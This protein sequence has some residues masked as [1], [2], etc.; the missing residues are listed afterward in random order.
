MDNTTD[1]SL[2]NFVISVT[3]KSYSSNLFLMNVKI[4]KMRNF[5]HVFPNNIVFKKPENLSITSDPLI[6]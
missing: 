2:F 3:L 5:V 4:P 1:S 6:V